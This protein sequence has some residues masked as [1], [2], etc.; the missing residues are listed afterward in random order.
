MAGT[1]PK[2]EEGRKV[3]DYL[4]GRKIGSGAMGEV[5]E[6]EDLM[7][8]GR[9]VAIKLMKDG[10]GVDAAAIRRFRR[11]ASAASKLR[12]NHVVILHVFGVDNGQWYLIMEYL[13]G[14]SLRQH[15]DASKQLVLS[16]AIEIL[17]PIIRAVAYAHGKGVIHRDL[18]PENIVIDEKDGA[19]R[20]VVV[21]FGIA[22]IGTDDG[23][24]Q[25][26][27]SRSWLGTRA[28]LAPELLTSVATEASDQF[29]LGVI[30]YE[31]LSGTHPFGETKKG[32]PGQLSVNASEAARL[33]AADEWLA[34]ILARML[35][36][37]PDDRYP[38]L[39]EVVSVLEQ[40]R[41]QWQHEPHS[42]APVD[43]GGKPLP[44]LQHEL[45][46][47]APADTGRRPWWSMRRVRLVVVATAFVGLVALVA[48]FLL[49]ESASE[50]AKGPSEHPPLAEHTPVPPPIKLLPQ[51]APAPPPPPPRATATKP[52]PDRATPRPRAKPSETKAPTSAPAETA[53]PKAA[54]SAPAKSVAD[55]NVGRLGDPSLDGD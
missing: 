40:N 23:P 31:A 3:G 44:L 42:A 49:R 8:P 34:E 24:G 41:P 2:A 27:W 6:A 55:T 16:N 10:P 7:V 15:L 26:T 18:K 13:A 28:Y 53:E 17:L 45:H 21:D 14:R 20:P 1:T 33:P 5:F 19:P 12:D 39:K 50:K 35:R 36:L 30:L 25:S 52:A 38:S 4:L 29:A 32:V 22:R 9:T 37:S 43:A 51:A 11:E 47:V 48:V 54:E 46:L